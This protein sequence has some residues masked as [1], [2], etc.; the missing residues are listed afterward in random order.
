MKHIFHIV[1]A[2]LSWILLGMTLLGGLARYISPEIW[3]FPQFMC[4]LLPVLTVL[5]LAM[6]LVWMFTRHITIPIATAVVLLAISPALTEIFPVSFPAKPSPGAPTLS[7]LTYNVHVFEDM[8]TGKKGSGRGLDYIL[9]SGAD[10]VCL[11]EVYDLNAVLKW[12]YVTPQQVKRSSEI[13]PYA[14]YNENIDVSVISKYPIKRICGVYNPKLYYFMYEVLEVAVPGHPLT[15]VNVHLTSFGLSAQEAGLLEDAADG[16]ISESSSSTVY[17]KLSLAFERR[18]E[19]ARQVADVVRNLKGDVILCGDFNDVPASYAYHTIREAG[20]RDAYL[21]CCFGPTATF[22]AHHLFF[23][24]DQVMYKGNLRPFS[25]TRGDLRASDH[26]PL[27]A[28]FQ[29]L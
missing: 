13:Y 4:L 17:R 5:S 9:N 12:G 2:I 24:I 7:V 6:G 22:N 14:L 20:L 26:Y 25:I 10:I 15:L 18:A 23:H 27:L 3:T 29:L 19:A 11:Q 28:R 8:E 16:D 21:D 1:P